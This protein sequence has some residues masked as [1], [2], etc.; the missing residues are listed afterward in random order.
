MDEGD[1]ASE[2]SPESNAESYAAFLVQFI[3]GKTPEETSSSSFFGGKSRDGNVGNVFQRHLTTKLLWY[4]V[5][6]GRNIFGT[7]FRGTS[8]YSL[9]EL[10]RYNLYS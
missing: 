7:I 5:D 4:V 2:M 10:S 8:Y 9:D 6:S 3:E 1:N